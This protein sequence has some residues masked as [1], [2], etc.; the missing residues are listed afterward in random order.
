MST[1]DTSY[2]PIEDY[3][4]IGDCHGAAL[5]SRH[6]SIDW[7]AALRLDGDPVFFRLFDAGGGGGWTISAEGARSTS[8][9]YLPRTN[10]LCT[11]FETSS[12][13]I[14]VLDFMPVGRTREA[15]TH[16]YVSLSAPGWIVR[17]LRCLSGDV[18]IRMTVSPRDAGFRTEPLA[19]RLEGGCIRFSNGATLW[20]DGQCSATDDGVAVSLDL[21]EGDCHDCVLTQVPPLFD[22]RTRAD[23]LYE[24][25]R[26]YWSEWCEYARYRGPYEDAVRRSALAL[27]LLT[28]APTGAIVAAPTTSLPEEIGGNRNWDYRF[29]WIRDAT[30]ALFALAVLGYSA[31][32]D[33][34][35]RFLRRNCLREGSTLR[36]MYG[37]DGEPF[38]AE[39]TLDHLDG[40]RSSRPVRVGNHAAEQ[41]QIDVFGELLDWAQL[42]VALGSR[43]GVDERALLR[44]VADHVCD[45][46]KLPDQGLWEMRCEPRHFTHG[47]VMAWVTLDRALDIFGPNAEW[48]RTRDE[49]LAWILEHGC[50]GSPPHLVQSDRDRKSDA[51]LL[52]VPLLGLPLDRDL[53]ARTVREV[54]RELRSDDVVYRYR[55]HDGLGGD[56]G[57]FFITSFWLVEA[58][59]VVGRLDEAEALFESLLSKANDVGLYAEEV[60]VRTGSFLGNF[61]QAFT[62][63]SLISSA[64]LLQLCKDRGTKALIGTNADRA[65]RI[66]GATA[67]AR[68]LAYALFRN[69]KVR[70]RSSRKSVMDLT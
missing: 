48:S 68:A 50:A 14:E 17:R 21:R 23:R 42:R 58:M 63:L 40:Y 11:R 52:Q 5:V 60:D 6:G 8:R 13:V 56:E 10:I 55:G 28:Y 7:C 65:K 49:I 15:G 59:V 20:T 33:R 69:R 34:F 3:A 45:V 51:A 27:K 44:G 53:L 18:R 43:L 39:K 36:I 70:L 29:S 67:G 38:L 35:A 64:A 12:G 62:H 26:A 57:A 1:Q 19:S 30:F 37:I 46:W 41:R 47:K 16:D 25:T 32:A 61:P 31:E 24:T 54:E 22:P 9:Q 66:T 4:L 2:S